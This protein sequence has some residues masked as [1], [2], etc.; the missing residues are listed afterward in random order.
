MWRQVVAVKI[1]KVTFGFERRR[2][3]AHDKSAPETD[4]LDLNFGGPLAIVDGGL[5]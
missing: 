5:P 3:F 1:G 2:H 4:I